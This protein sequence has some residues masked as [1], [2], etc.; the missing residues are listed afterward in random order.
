MADSL[1]NK[2]IAVAGGRRF[3]DIAKIIA[4][5]GGAAVLRPMM[6]LSSNDKPGVAKAVTELAQAG[7]DWLVVVTG[8]GTKA[9]V[10]KAAELGFEAEL[11]EILSSARVAARGYK[12]I[13]ALKALDVVPVVEDDDG[14]VLG[15]QRQLEPYPFKG[16]RVTLQLHGE[17]MPELSDWLLERG[18]DVREI[19]LYFYDPPKQTDLQTLL[20]EILSAELDA[21]AFTSNTQVK[22]LFGGAAKL[23]AED[24]LRRAFN[25]K[26]V[27]LS[28]GH[29]TSQSLSEFGVTRIIA[30]EH[31]R[32]GAMVM[33]LG[34]YYADSAL[35]ASGEAR[36]GASSLP[37]TLTATRT[38][39]VVGGGTVAT[40]KV[41]ALLEARVKPVVVSP[42]LTPELSRL[43]TESRLEHRAK[44]YEPADLN[45]VD[46]VLAATQ[47]AQVNARV[48]E[49]ARSRGLLCN[50]VDAPD[51]SSFTSLGT[52]RRGDLTL[53]VA[54][55][56][57][58][59]SL[60][61]Y[62]RT[63]LES[64]FPAG[65]AALLS[66]LAK[67]RSSLTRLT[68]KQR[69]AALDQLTQTQTLNHLEQLELENPDLAFG[70]VAEVL[71]RAAAT[72]EPDTSSHAQRSS[73]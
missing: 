23:G 2:R 11:K 19:P 47:D 7:T 60:S 12:T 61:R 70:L 44:V 65:Y 3:D 53:S 52:V 18:A 28:V 8:V 54:T 43:K 67:E 68:P 39:L 55:G 37:V 40:R 36:S 31:E 14:T 4:K 15:L 22:F 16:E 46:I 10:K 32:M 38:A 25:N 29:V 57:T 21:V 1:K 42:H 51:L 69:A 72:L 66:A 34:A 45:G 27:A 58:S 62:I 6:G 71:A 41:K 9:L 59:P 30:P 24:H 56:G 63:K 17:R 64:E 48:S 20:F 49:D 33:A 50:V 73:L 5:Q 13:K 26:V 35:E